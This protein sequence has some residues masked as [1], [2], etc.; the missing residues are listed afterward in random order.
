MSDAQTTFRLRPRYSVLAYSAIIMGLVLVAYAI[1]SGGA[2]ALSVSLGITGVTL[3][4][5]YLASPIW[6]LRIVVTDDGMEVQGKKALRFRLSWDDI[7]Q[8]IVAPD[9]Q[10]C[11]VHGGTSDRSLLVPGPRANARYDIENKE[12]LY[13]LL[14]ER[15]PS[16]RQLEVEALGKWLKAERRRRTNA[17]LPPEEPTEDGVERES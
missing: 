9:D 4:L 5:L 6:R 16:D 2:Q 15:V 13:Q 17:M 10:T 11:F 3:G 1:G 14:R 12:R 7:E 8:L